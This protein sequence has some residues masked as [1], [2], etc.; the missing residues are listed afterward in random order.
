MKKPRPSRPQHSPGQ[1][2][3]IGGQWRSRKLAVAAVDGLRPSAD[4]VRETLF[5]WLAPDISGARCLD[6]FAGSGA[7]SFEALSRGAA[8]A[9]MIELSPL[10]CQQLRDNISLLQAAGATLFNG[11]ATDWLRQ[12]RPAQPFHIVFIDPPFHRG[13]A[14]Q[15]IAQLAD[16]ALLTSGSKIYLETGDDEVIEQLPAN[17][18]LWREKRAGR[19]CF[20]L[21]QCL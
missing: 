21:F 1:L 12:S 10:A 2:R 16:S 5:N 18:Q 15:C 19:V 4:R 20:R 14:Q 7:L 3:I 13:L 8:S 9:Q 17:W 6:L 11:S